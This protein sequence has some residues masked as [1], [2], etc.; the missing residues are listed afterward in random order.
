MKKFAN[1]FLVFITF[2][3]AQYNAEWNSGNLGSYGWGNAIID[4]DNDGLCELAVNANNSLTFY[5]GD[6]TICWSIPFSGFPYT[7]YVTPRDVNGDG[8][9]VLTN[10]DN[11][12]SAELVIYGYRVTP[13]YEGKIRV[14]DAVTRN[15]EWESPLISGLCNANIE[16]I[17][18]DN[19]AEIIVNRIVSSTYYV[20]VYA[21]SGSSINDDIYSHKSSTG[22]FR[23]PIPQSALPKDSEIYDLLGRIQK[24]QDITK[25]I[26][27]LDYQGRRIKVIVE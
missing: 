20:D 18:G 13:Q 1:L 10:T 22:F 17:D 7:G 5:N 14:Y 27:F 6:Y 15:L 4:I 3:F 11:D 2:C 12:A 23:N 16:D 21:Y 24:T 25:G 9:I 26:Y 8:L 19:K